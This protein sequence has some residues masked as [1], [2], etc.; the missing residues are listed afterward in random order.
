M[1]RLVTVF[2]IFQGFFQLSYGQSNIV[3]ALKVQGNKR[4][5]AS[6]VRSI[7]DIKSGSIL[8]STILERDIIRLKRLPA[9]S[10]AYYQVFTSDKDNT[11]NVFY[12]IEENFTLNPQLNVLSLIHI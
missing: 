5:K 10:H 12:N 8:D 2:L 1:F 7:S 9:V 6:F 3:E 4:L 11:Y